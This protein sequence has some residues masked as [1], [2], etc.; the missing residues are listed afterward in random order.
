LGAPADI[1]PLKA[2]F[3]AKF[4]ALATH[5]RSFLAAADTIV[6]RTSPGMRRL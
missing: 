6:R 5:L 2:Q 1:G 4:H 3:R